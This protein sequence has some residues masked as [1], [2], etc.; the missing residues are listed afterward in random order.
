M[1]V[2][3]FQAL[4]AGAPGAACELHSCDSDELEAQGI[5]SSVR[6]AIQASAA[7]A[8]KDLVIRLRACAHWQ[9]HVRKNVCER[10]HH[11]RA[12]ALKHCCCC[13]CPAATRAAR[14]DGWVRK[15]VPLLVAAADQRNPATLAD[16]VE[17]QH[18]LLAEEQQAHAAAAA[19][20]TRAAVTGLHA[21]LLQLQDSAAHQLSLLA[22]AECALAP[23]LVALQAQVSQSDVQV[24]QLE[25][26]NQRLQG[27]LLLQQKDQGRQHSAAAAAA[28]SCSRE[29]ASHSLEET[30]DAL[31]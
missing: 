4:P 13:C 30:L 23:A 3:A 18:T 14:G 21:A 15:E 25:A 6:A 10:T 24:A 16:Y 22:H 19:A 17:L 12:R 2:T 7:G 5:D 20:P 27:L 8:W 29:L 9:V 31:K 1:Q 26:D 11:M 28:S